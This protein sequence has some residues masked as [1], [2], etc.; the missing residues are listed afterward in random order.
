MAEEQDF[1]V[2]QFGKIGEHMVGYELSKRGWVI[3]YPPYDERTD[4]V[5]MKFR[6]KKCQAPWDI[7]HRIAC[8]N[9]KCKEFGVFISGINGKNQ[10]KNKKCANGHI[11]KREQ[12]NAQISICPTCKSKK[13][14]EIALCPVCHTEIGVFKKT[15]SRYPDC[16]GE[17]YEVLFR[18]IQVKSS[19]IV[20]GGKNIGFN[21]KYQDLIDDA[22]H[23]LIV[24]NRRI[25]NDIERHFYWVLTVEDF[26][27]IKKTDT[28]SF[29]IYQNDRGHY[30]P[31]ILKPYLFNETEFYKLEKDKFK[32]QQEG[33]KKEAEKINNEQHKIDVFRKL[34]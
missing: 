27:N 21:F 29:K 18:S 4:I 23:F 28:I 13:L 16:D 20:D 19:H 32:A 12:G 10:Y 1:K 34:D 14:E 8:L 9:P 26:K 7:E 30:N 5:A 33:K 31:E 3:F 11:I 2:G 15:C 22:R 17:K 25:I 24:Y 6:C